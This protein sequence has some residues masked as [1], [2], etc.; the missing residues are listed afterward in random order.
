MRLDS[1]AL[2]GI[3][4]AAGSSPGGS[5]GLDARS[6]IAVLSWGADPA[7]TALRRATTQSTHAPARTAVV[8]AMMSVTG[9]DNLTRRSRAAA[10]IKQRICDTGTMGSTLEQ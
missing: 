4:A 8:P 6:F 9:T 1:D 7:R 10:P 3:P 5:G 2:R